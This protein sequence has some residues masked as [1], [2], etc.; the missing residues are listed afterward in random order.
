MSSY[1][2]DIIA[3]EVKK[4]RQI[5]FESAE[6][7]ERKKIIRSEYKEELVKAEEVRGIELVVQQ[8]VEGSASLEP[9]RVDITFPLQV[10]VVAILHRGSE[11]REVVLPFIKNVNVYAYIKYGI[12]ELNLVLQPK[13]HVLLTK[14]TVAIDKSMLRLSKLEAVKVRLKLSKPSPIPLPI[15]G[16]VRVSLSEKADEVRAVLNV[17]RIKGFN[18]LDL[19]FTGDR[20]EEF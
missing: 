18:M 5:R 4:E 20:V 7:E 13:P 10:P 17:E 8:E 19:L 16:G 3:V 1:N 11:L 9:V 12:R 14:F 15:L 2:Q 6:E